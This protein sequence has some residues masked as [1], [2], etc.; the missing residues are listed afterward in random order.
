M[1]NGY[2]RKLNVIAPQRSSDPIRGSLALLPVFPGLLVILKVF[3]RQPAQGCPGARP[4][5]RAVLL[6]YVPSPLRRGEARAPNA[7]NSR[8]V[9]NLLSMKGFLKRVFAHFAEQSQ[10]LSVTYNEFGRELLG[11]PGVPS[12]VSSVVRQTPTPRSSSPRPRWTRTS[13]PM[14]NCFVRSTRR[15]SSDP[16]AAWSL[17]T[18]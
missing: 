13:V 2:S 7:S 16:R 9:H 15:C 1:A 6:P 5:F 18:G 17:V 10:V 12:P 14:P 8:L 3:A 4:G 11:S